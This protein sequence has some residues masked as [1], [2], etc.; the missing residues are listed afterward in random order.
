[1][2][3]PEFYLTTDPGLKKTGLI[4]FLNFLRAKEVGFLNFSKTE[5]HV[6]LQIKGVY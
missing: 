2:D 1:M 5:K 3:S 6:I 4:E